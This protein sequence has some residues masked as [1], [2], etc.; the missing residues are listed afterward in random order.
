MVILTICCTLP[1]VTNPPTTAFCK[2]ACAR[3]RT[4]R[5]YASQLPL[6]YR[7]GGWRKKRLR[8]RAKTLSAGTHTLRAKTAT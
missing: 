4:K 5:Q 3:G 2:R 1:I 8:S 6:M 7:V